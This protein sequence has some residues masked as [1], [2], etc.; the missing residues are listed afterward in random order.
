MVLTFV[1]IKYE[2]SEASH[3]QI[4]SR[5]EGCRYD[6]WGRRAMSGNCGY[7]KIVK[8]I[9][10]R[11]ERSRAKSALRRGEDMQSREAF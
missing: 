6:F 10:T 5:I 9:T 1:D 11:I 7:G 3:E 4:N 2:L 8:K